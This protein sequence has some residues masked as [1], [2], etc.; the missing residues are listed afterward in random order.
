[1]VS[2]HGEITHN[3]HDYKS[4][5]SGQLIH[6]LCSS[7]RKKQKTASIKRHSHGSKIYICL[8]LSPSPERRFQVCSITYGTNI[9]PTLRTSSGALVFLLCFPLKSATNK[10]EWP[11]SVAGGLFV[12]GR[13]F[14]A[15]F[16][17]TK[18]WPF[19]QRCDAM[20]VRVMP[21]GS[22]RPSSRLLQALK[23]L[24][25]GQIMLVLRGPQFKK[26]RS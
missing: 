8:I 19:P 22:R 20:R 15:C 16:P 17:S 3:P 11:F 7:E 14:L 21:F 9:R 26:K 12:C 25:N 13:T 24:G 18:T 1:M 4:P 10:K 2:N 23:R 5:L 6:H